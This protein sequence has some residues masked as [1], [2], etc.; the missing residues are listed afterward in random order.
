V[1]DPNG[2]GER[3]LEAYEELFSRAFSSRDPLAV[4]RAARDD[5]S[6]PAALREAL[7][8]LDEHG[9][10]ISSLIVTRL[11]FERLLNGSRAA[12]EWFE[13]DPADFTAAFK[14]YQDQVP[15]ETA[16][17]QDEARAF[18]VWRRREEARGA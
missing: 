11:R 15:P 16:F 8:S 4:L 14:R 7:S 2:A 3:E 17:A 1:A 9:V 12:G 18:E 6:T 5:S 13:R 10:R